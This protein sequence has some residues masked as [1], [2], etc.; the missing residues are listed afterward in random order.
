MRSQRKGG[1]SAITQVKVL[2]PEISI[3][4]MGQ[5]FHFLEASNA[6]RA[7]GECIATCRGLSPW[8]AVQRT[9]SELGRSL[10]LPTEASNKLKRQ[11][12]GMVIGKSDQL[13]VCAGQRTDQEG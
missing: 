12:G 2:S 9:T 8:Q 3:I 4:A 6:V 10:S 5:G 1:R 11:G 13:I 7:K